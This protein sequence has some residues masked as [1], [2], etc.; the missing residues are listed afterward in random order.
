MFCAWNKDDEVCDCY[1]EGNTEYCASHNALIRKR[2][3][4]KGKE[5]KIYT[6]KKSE[7]KISPV[8]K[9]KAKVIKLY[10]VIRSEF[11][12]NHPSCEI[13]LIGCLGVSTEIHHVSMSHI[14]FTNPATFKSTCRHCH[15]IVETVLSAADRRKKGLLV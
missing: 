14:D 13:M 3:R 9:K 12:N 7:K 8:S 1:I 6:L 4:S 10:T 2:N 15:V 5:K 11:L